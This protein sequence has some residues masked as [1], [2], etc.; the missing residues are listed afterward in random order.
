MLFRSLI[1]DGILNTGIFIVELL[2]NAWNI[3]IYA[4][5]M[6]W[7]GLNVLVR[8]VLQAILNIGI[9]IAEGFANAWNDVIYGLQMAFYMFQTF[10][11]KILKAV[12]QGALGVVNA[13][14][15]GISSLVNTAISG[16][17]GLIGMANK[18]PGVNIGTIGTV[19]FKVGDGAQS[20][21]D[22]IGSDLV[23]PVRAERVSLGRSTMGQ[24]YMDNVNVPSMPEMV[25]LGRSSV[26]SDFLSSIDM[27]EFPKLE[28]TFDTL[29]FKDMGKAFDAGYK[30]GENLEQ[31][32]KDFSLKD[33]LM[34]WLGMDM[35][36][37]DD[38][39]STGLE[40]IGDIPGIDELGGLGDKAD[41]ATRSC[42]RR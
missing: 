2:A 13:V 4:I 9:S 20:A 37:M 39:L 8:N 11:S 21:I 6:L 33:T 34:D 10:V 27:P 31:K 12:G 30:W 28:Q 14:L 1:F 23:A 26:A 41:K 5:M 17:N 25:S 16:L 40:G 38:L 42:C 32:A 22:S 18:I 15:G 3:G 36:N 24:D 7:I 19:D 35:P 29:D